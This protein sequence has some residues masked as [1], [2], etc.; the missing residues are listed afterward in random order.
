MTVVFEKRHSYLY[1]KKTGKPEMYDRIKKNNRPHISDMQGKDKIDGPYPKGILLRHR[2]LWNKENYL[3]LYRFE[4][5]KI[6]TEDSS[7][8]WL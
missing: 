3:T 1:N 6:K 4:I 7:R 5:A 2:H 8:L